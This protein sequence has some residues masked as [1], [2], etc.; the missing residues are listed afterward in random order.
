MLWGS[1][2]S[3]TL[4]TGDDEDELSSNL[5]IPS[6]SP[7][8]IGHHLSHAYSGA[9]LAVFNN[10]MN[11]GVVSVM[12]GM[13][14]TWDMGKHERDEWEEG[15]TAVLQVSRGRRGMVDWILQQYN[16]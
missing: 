13:G 16:L 5:N 2:L 12:D 4:S 1:M 10:G 11:K 9:S 3:T 6:T 15:F 14:D 8:T 7:S